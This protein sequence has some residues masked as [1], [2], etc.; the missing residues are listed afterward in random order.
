[1][2][3]ERDRRGAIADAAIAI[4]G[5]RGVRALTHR[6]VDQSLA[7]PSGSTS[8]YFRSRHA[9][10]SG[11]VARLAERTREDLQ[12]SRSRAAG[13]APAGREDYEPVLA[14][15]LELW[16]RTAGTLLDRM[17]G[18]RRADSMARYALTLELVTDPE[19]HRILTAGQPIREFAEIELR[20]LGAPD[21]AAAATDLVSLADGLVFDS[22]AGTRSL[23][24]PAP[25][26]ADSI[27][28][29][30]RAV[31]TFLTG[32]FCRDF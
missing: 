25:G 19:L 13:A 16:A 6:A 7:L 32:V 20:R 10:L 26:S 2:T 1:M 28:Q 4:V 12:V 31:R 30:S 11:V 17:I 27:D 9:L 5:E 23:T 24:A 8:Y 15:Q 21:P 14:D 3:D 18:E 22:L 29:L